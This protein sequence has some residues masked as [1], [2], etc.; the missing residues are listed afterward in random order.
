[1]SHYNTDNKRLINFY[2]NHKIDWQY[3]DKISNITTDELT[4][5]KVMSLNIHKFISINSN[6]QSNF[7]LETILN[8]CSRANIDICCMEEYYNDFIIPHPIYDYIINVNHKGLVILYKKTLT[9]QNVSSYK[10]PNDKR[11]DPLRFALCFTINN[12]KII[13]T[14]LEIGLRLYNSRGHLLSDDYV[15]VTKKYNSELRIKQ[16][17]TIINLDPDFILGDFNFNKN[18]IE[19]R[20]MINNNYQTYETDY[21]TP[22]GTQVDF[23]FAK[24]PNRCSFFTK[25]NFPYSDHLPII[26]I[27][28]LN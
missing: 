11:L 3:I 21:T 14:H 18:D 6:D 22:Y 24:K 25:I 23:I 16:L 28:I 13:L 8:I 26:G 9:I 2:L 5:L 17:D 27:I 19:F 1:M 7:I 10:L 20:F 4:T 15:H 12:K